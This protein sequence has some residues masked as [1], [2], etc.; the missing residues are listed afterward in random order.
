[1]VQI[2]DVAELAGVS[3]ATV[4][5]VLTNRGQ[6]RGSTRTR[7]NAAIDQ[8]GYQP[9]RVARSLR[10]RSAQIIGLI[11]S[12]I[13][14][15]FFTSLVRAVEDVAYENRYAIFLC[16]S[17][18]DTAKESLY[19]DLMISEKVAGVILTTTQELHNSC[20]KLIQA[21]I[22][23]VSVDR[24]VRNC[25]VDTVVLDNV[26]GAFNL[27]DHLIQLGHTRVGLI[28]GVT[29]MTTGRER[30]EGYCAA[31][32]A[33]SLPTHSELVRFGMPTIS[34]GYQLTEKL[35]ALN[36]PPSAIFTANNMFTVGAL[37]AIQANCLKVPD[38]ISLVAFDDPEWVTLVQPKLTV[39]A[40]PTYE[41]GQKAAQLI[42]KRIEDSTRPCETI[43]L[44]PKMQFRDSVKDYHLKGEQLRIESR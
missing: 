8:L 25:E 15:P 40:Q 16:N 31:L 6:V 42:L 43:V 26:Q 30:Y 18:E 27:V 36:D 38:D 9:S 37:H 2:K 17:D 5:R 12:D 24:R 32:A 13:Q 33:H 7:V 20:H 29:S 3:T 34:S 10:V 41:L 44:P 14:N 35:L 28:T 4:S 21:K 39:V 23:T 22:P 1:V 11:I 19:I